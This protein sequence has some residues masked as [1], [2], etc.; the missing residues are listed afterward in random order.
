MKQHS[1][2]LALAIPLLA[3]LQPDFHVQVNLVRVPCV[4]TDATGAPVRSLRRKDFV[5]MDDGVPHEVQYL[6]QEADLPLTVG[7]VADVSGSEY[8]FLA[9]H[10]QTVVR[11]LSQSLSPNDRAFLVSVEKQQR[12]VID[13]TNSIEK[14]QAG[15]EGLGQQQ[16][17]ILGDPCVITTYVL[18]QPV[19]ARSSIALRPVDVGSSDGLDR[20]V[21]FDQDAGPAGTP[22]RD[23]STPRDRTNEQITKF[24]S[25]GDPPNWSG[26]C[27]SV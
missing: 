8:G 12:L 21:P 7:L 19:T 9:Q 1:L 23:R 10:R 6:W 3:Q 15:V 11:F 5:V 24:R 4:V 2:A 20:R 17:E 22:A 14:L 18:D 13:L 16:A 25:A 27:V 26:S